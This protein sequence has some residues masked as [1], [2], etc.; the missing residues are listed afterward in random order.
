MNLTDE[1]HYY[2]TEPSQPFSRHELEGF[3][4]L[5]RRL[6]MRLRFDLITC[7]TPHAAPFLASL[8]ALQTICKQATAGEVATSL[9]PEEVDP[10][11]RFLEMD[12]TDLDAF[13]QDLIEGLKT[14]A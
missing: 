7:K 12:L 5:M 8:V 6:E 4:D 3:L 13:T 10:F 9:N 11:K 14:D 2:P 1:Q